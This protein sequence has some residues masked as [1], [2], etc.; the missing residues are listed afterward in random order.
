MRNRNTLKIRSLLAVDGIS[1]LE[2]LK[3][4]DPS[5]YKKRESY[6]ENK[7]AFYK[8]HL[9]YLEDRNLFGLLFENKNPYYK[10][11]KGFKARMMDLLYAMMG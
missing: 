5:F 10:E 7:I 2:A 8:E 9:K 6:Y 4:T 3:E 11:F 1:M